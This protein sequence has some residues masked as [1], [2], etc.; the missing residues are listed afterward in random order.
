M[1]VFFSFHS[2]TRKI[3]TG[4]C[5]ASISA[6]HWPARESSTHSCPPRCSVVKK[7]CASPSTT[8]W[9]RYTHANVPARNRNTYQQQ[10]FFCVC[11]FN[12]AEGSSEDSVLPGVNFCLLLAAPSSQPH[13]EENNLRPEWPQPLWTAQVGTHTRLHWKRHENLLFSF[14]WLPGVFNVNF[15]LFPAS[16]LLVMDYIGINMASL[17]S[18]INP[19]ALYFVS[20]K[21]KNCF[22][23][24]WSTLAPKCGIVTTRS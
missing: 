10:H 6:S 20:Q 15:A 19:I 24:R 21:F 8:T 17:N 7:A 13:S 1:Y 14:L 22:Q 23:V 5:L 16:F 2:S 12:K 4:G 9:N 3:K 18:C 11:V